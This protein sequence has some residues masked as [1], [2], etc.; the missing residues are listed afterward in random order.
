MELDQYL[1][2][3]RAAFGSRGLEPSRAEV[4]GRAADAGQRSDFRWRWFGVR[5]HTAVIV[6]TFGAAEARRDELDRF[7]ADASQ[8]SIAHRSGGVRGMQSG[9]AAVAVAVLPDGAGEAVEWASRPHGSRYAALA[10]PVA[11]DLR[12]GTVTQPARLRAGWIFQ[13]F[14]RQLVHDVVEVPLGA[15][16]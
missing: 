4:A 16:A 14:L 5:L 11:V 13:G 7:L 2:G 10:Y 3:V 6:A 12:G 15:A 1:T 9:T 8:W